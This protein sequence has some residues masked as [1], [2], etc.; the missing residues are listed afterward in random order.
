MLSRRDYKSFKVVFVLIGVC[1]VL[2]GFYT[3]L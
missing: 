1:T 3:A 2:E